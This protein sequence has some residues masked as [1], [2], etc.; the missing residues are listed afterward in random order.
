MQPRPIVETTSPSRPRV[1]VPTGG[2]EFMPASSPPS[3]TPRQVPGLRAEPGPR[4]VSPGTRRRPEPAPGPVDVGRVTV[5]LQLDGDDTASLG[6]PVEQVP[7]HVGEPEAAVHDDERDPAGA[8]A[9]PV[10]P[11]T[12]DRRVALRNLVLDDAHAGTTLP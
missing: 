6:Q 12:V 5:S 10:H 9:A 7:V 8:D 1:R 11:D 2:S 4:N 3:S